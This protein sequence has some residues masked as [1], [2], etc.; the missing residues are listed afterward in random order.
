MHQRDSARYLELDILV[1]SADQ[2]LLIDAAI[3]VIENGRKKI[4]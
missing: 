1:Q 4:F 2:L 3:L